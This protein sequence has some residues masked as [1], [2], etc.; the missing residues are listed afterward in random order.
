MPLD[1]NS[2]DGFMY[3]KQEAPGKAFFPAVSLPVLAFKKQ[4]T[5]T[6]VLS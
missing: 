3:H 4:M 6:E 5:R 1:E 2:S